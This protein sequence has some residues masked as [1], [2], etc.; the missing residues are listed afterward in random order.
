MTS[1]RRA[2]YERIL[3]PMAEPCRRWRAACPR[4][5][6]LAAWLAQAGSPTDTDHAGRSAPDEVRQA[7]QV[8]H[9]I[10]ER[11]TVRQLDLALGLEALHRPSLRLE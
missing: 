9:Y 6:L 3:D 2:L 8:A 10:R 7:V 4:P 5:T 11:F 1:P